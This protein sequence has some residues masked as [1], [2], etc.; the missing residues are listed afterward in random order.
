MAC[1]RLGTILHLEIQKGKEVMKTLT[2]QK[3][4]GG[5]AA[6]TK[7]LMMDTKGYGQLTSNDTYFSDSWFSGVET[8]EGVD[9][10]ELAK[11][12]HKGFCLAK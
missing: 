4:I 3:Y 6:C 10:C 12:I 2:F 7:R 1:S 11:T 8:A 5:T 9:Y